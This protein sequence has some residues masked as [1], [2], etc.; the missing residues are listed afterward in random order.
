MTFRHL[1]TLAAFVVGCAALLILLVTGFAWCVQRAGTLARRWA[2]SIARSATPWA[3]PLQVVLFGL[4]VVSG[5]FAACWLRWWSIVVVVAVVAVQVLL[6]L[7]LQHGRELMADID[8]H[9]HLTRLDTEIGFGTETTRGQMVTAAATWPIPPAPKS[10]P[11]ARPD[12]SDHQTRESRSTVRRPNPPDPARYTERDQPGFVT[13]DAF[14]PGW[15][16]G[17]T[18]RVTLI[19]TV[20][21]PITVHASRVQIHHTPKGTDQ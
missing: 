3:G 21:N 11:Q 10:P 9:E 17:L 4:V 1:F 6:T 7:W 13:A 14:G 20:A 18:A 2:R 16:D 19:P 15:S 8:R 12:T 5:V